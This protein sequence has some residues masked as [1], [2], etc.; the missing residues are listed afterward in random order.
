[1]DILFMNSLQRKEE[2]HSLCTARI[3]VGID[4]DHWRIVWT[5]DR[6]DQPSTQE[7]WYEGP[8]QDE[9]KAILQYRLAGK[10]GDGFLPVVEGLLEEAVPVSN[11]ASLTQMLHY[12]AESNPNKTL[13][14]KLRTWRREKAGEVG[15]APFVVATNKLLQLL[16][17]YI[18]HHKEEMLQ[19][20]GFG[21][22]KWNLFG[23]ELVSLL[24]KES[25]DH[26]FP[27]EWVAQRMD[28][29][30]M[31][32]WMCRQ[33]EQKHKNMLA[34]HQHRKK[35]LA[36]ASQRS[37]LAELEKELSLPKREIIMQLEQLESE[38]YDL[39]VLIDSCGEEIPE[40]LKVRAI[41]AFREQDSRF[42]KP[43]LSKLYTEEE[44]K[45]QDIQQLYDWLRLV[46]MVARREP[47]TVQS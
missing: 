3:C 41:Q 20:P 7:D 17:V 1:M 45:G 4:E 25:R 9:M 32:I 36:R 26:T 23:E 27:L 46:R 28:H 19:I 15:R 47:S 10:M 33:H 44:L 39:T 5:E 40:Q 8:E 29:R 12:Y 35:L 43:V 30:E 16:S 18:P 42:L 21:E 13:Y 38:G 2:Q 6:M 22:Y 31:F 24:A 14:D 34:R 37:T 11:R